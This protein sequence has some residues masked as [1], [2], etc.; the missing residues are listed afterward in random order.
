MK[1]KHIVFDF[2]NV[3]GRFDEDDILSHFF[4]NKADFPVLKK[5]IFENWKALDAGAID[6]EENITHAVSLV[7]DHLKESVRS[8]FQ[9]WNKY[10]TPLTQTWELVR[11]LKDKGYSLYILSNASVNFAEHASQYDITKEFDGIVF[12]AVIQML[13][14][15]PNIYQYLFDTYHLDPSEC[16]FIDDLEENIAAAR[17]LGMDGIVF[18]GNINAVKDAIG[19]G[20]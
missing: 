11:E 6:Y 12:S 8:F 14:P 1:Y 19:I 13:K 16:F 17:N 15:N 4:Y 10:L 2:G 9:D 20:K 5:A 7:P 3:L 18:T